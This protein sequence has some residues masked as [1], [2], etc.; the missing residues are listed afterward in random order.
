MISEFFNTARCREIVGHE[1][2]NISA[3][4]P[5][6]NDPFFASSMTIFTRVLSLNALKISAIFNFTYVQDVE[7]GGECQFK[8]LFNL[9]FICP[10]R[11]FAILSAEFMFNRFRRLLSKNHRGQAEF[12]LQD[13]CHRVKHRARDR[14][15]ACFVPNPRSALCE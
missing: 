12:H 9:F 1:V 13:Y 7:R 2:S 14:D 8:F 5:D 15:I 6:C 11:V 3:I 4:W 10:Q